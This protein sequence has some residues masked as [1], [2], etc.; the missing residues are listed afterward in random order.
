MLGSILTNVEHSE[1]SELSFSVTPDVL[2]PT[3]IHA[4]IGS[5]G[6]GKTTLIK[7]MIKSI[8]KNDNTNGMFKYADS[9]DEEEEVEEVVEE[10]AE[11]QHE[12][13]ETTTEITAEVTEETTEAT[14]EESTEAT[15]EPAAEPLPGPTGIS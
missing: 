13:T 15:T 12:T 9:D 5:N 7:N 10:E 3:N 11:H 2:P 1:G 14:T 4:V 8:C 6:V